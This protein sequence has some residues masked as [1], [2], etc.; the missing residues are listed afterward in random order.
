[1]HFP[2]LQFII[3]ICAFPITLLFLVIAGVAVRR[4]TR[5]L[6]W[7]I[8]FIELCGLAYFVFKLFRLF[9]PSQAFR[10]Q[11]SQ[12]TL[13][14]FSA[15][16]I[17]MLLSTAVNTIICYSNYGEGLKENIPGYWGEHKDNRRRNLSRKASLGVQGILDPA[18]SRMSID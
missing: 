7:L 18:Q 9:Q 2:V 16:A 1:M 4:E 12:K 8:F 15:L 3:T 17:V 6:T 11:T 10:Y 5:W 14:V 13:A